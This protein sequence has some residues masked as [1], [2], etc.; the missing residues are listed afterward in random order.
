MRRRLTDP[1]DGVRSRA[2]C[3]A[4]RGFSL[5]AAPR[6]EATDRR[7]LE[8]LC[9]YVIRPPV[10]SGR[11][12]CLDAETLSF[13]LKTPWADGTASLLL[14]PQELP[15]K[16]AALEPPPRLN[17]VRY[18]GVLAPACP[19]RA[20]IVPGPSALT[21]DEGCEHDDAG[22]AAGRRA[23][24]ICWAKLLARV[25]QYDVTVCP[26]CSGHMQETS[27]LRDRRPYRARRHP[28]LS[29]GRR[30]AAQSPP[31]FTPPFGSPTRIR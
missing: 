13:A 11:L 1:E 3:Y 15:E 12:R 2:L 17:L 31:P 18:H 5:H 19:D 26:R 4:S 10:A 28:G 21:Q 25:F 27:G 9:R 29:H 22:G 8:Q 24:R 20:Q 16:L 6:V 23:Q 14:S 30:P 7:R